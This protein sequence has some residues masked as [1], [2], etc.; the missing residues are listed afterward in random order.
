MALPR[1]KIILALIP[2]LI[3]TLAIIVFLV[4]FYWGDITIQGQS[5]FAVQYNGIQYTDTDG[6]VQI[7]SRAGNQTFVISKDQYENQTIDQD[8]AWNQPNLL[9][10]H[11]TYHA[12]IVSN[13]VFTPP[14]SYVNPVAVSDN[15][16]SDITSSPL[17][18]KI[19][20]PAGINNVVW[21]RDGTQA[22]L[23]HTG[24]GSIQ[25]QLLTAKSDSFSA[26]PLSESTFDCQSG[27]Q[28]V[29]TLSLEDNSIAID[30]K[31]FSLDQFS[32]WTVTS[33]L[34]Q[35]EVFIVGQKTNNTKKTIIAWNLDSNTQKD[36]GDWDIT[37]VVK[38]I[39][40]GSLAIPQ[41]KETVIVRDGQTIIKIASTA[42]PNSILLNQA[43]DTLYF[44]DSDHSLTFKNVFQENSAPK[45]LFQQSIS[46]DKPTSIYTLNDDQTLLTAKLSPDLSEGWYLFDKPTSR[47]LKVTIAPK[48]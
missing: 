3:T 33:S 29:H 7:R 9:V 6:K 22:C 11:F 42:N 48:K 13:D 4:F 40:P 17:A 31:H 27:P 18:R 38:I 39:G 2:F 8:I 30:T 21:S 25:N 16:L 10:A 41:V 46:S 26:D 1:K 5:P 44:I 28:Q 37:G 19:A 45:L 36:W 24:S 32:E 34:Y 12:Q 43:G 15:Q 35:N 23:L 20:L 14:I 47:L